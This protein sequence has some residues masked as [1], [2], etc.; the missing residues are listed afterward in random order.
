MENHSTVAASTPK[1]PD[2]YLSGIQPSGELHLGNYFG[3]IQQHVAC[4]TEGNSFY[5]IANYHA[6][7]TIHD[8]GRL[9]DLTHR[10]AATYLA[11]GLD[12]ERS[13][14]F[15]QSDVPEVTE[16][17]W[18]LL[19]ATSMGDLQR[20]VSYKDKVERG[21]P[22]SAGLFVYPVLMAAD[23]LAYESTIVPV[24]KDQVQHVEM[25]RSMARSFNDQYG[26]PV[27]TLPKHQLSK[28]AAVPGIDGAKMS[29]SYGN[30]IPLFL[31]GKPLK[32]LVMSIETDSTSLEAPKD[33]N[34]CTV[35]AL[36]SLFADEAEQAE[37]T[38]RYRAGNFGYGQAKQLLL[39]R[40]ERHFED[41]RRRFQ[42]LIEDPAYVEDVLKAGAQKAREVAR[43]V[44]DH[45]RAACGVA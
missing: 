14:F 18:L 35:F 37:L 36:Y 3:A 39:E 29:K 22:A 27:F 15:R 33:P 16:L 25:T 31:S 10:V 43:K 6:L 11:C 41:G 34:T 26:A 8:G 12:P 44:T 21:L 32:K 13:V 28:G 17:T 20:A 2:R 40:I 7:T 1:P 24:G 19:T 45:A 9:R 30:T 42:E 5:F 38:E 4:Q 23:I